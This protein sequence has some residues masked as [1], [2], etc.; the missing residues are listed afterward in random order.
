MEAIL[1]LFLIFYV[2]GAIIN[3]VAFFVLLA[4]GDIDTKKEFV[5]RLIPFPVWAIYW[6]VREYKKLD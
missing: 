4:E 6:V 5:L 2:I 3:Y 1:F